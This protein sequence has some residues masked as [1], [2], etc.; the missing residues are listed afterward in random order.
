MAI[1][2]ISIRNVCLLFNT[3]D[4]KLTVNAREY[5]SFDTP[6][7]RYTARATTHVSGSPG[8]CISCAKCSMGLVSPDV[9][10]LALVVTIV[11]ELIAT[12]LI[13]VDTNASSYHL[14]CFDVY[15][16]Y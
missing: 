5:Y 12:F 6:E 14:Y 9:A 10:P 1:N 8:S 15:Y 13:S 11:T 2:T 7:D 16:L 3:N 4:H